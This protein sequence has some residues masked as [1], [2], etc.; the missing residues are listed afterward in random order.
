M[1]GYVINNS[2]NVGKSF[3]ARELGYSNFPKDEENAII[4][5]ETHNS[6]TH[7]FK[8]VNVIKFSGDQIKDI[9]FEILKYDNCI[10]D[11]GASNI[12]KF[13]A[14]LSRFKDLRD[15]VDHIIVPAFSGDKQSEDTAKTLNIL[16]TLGLD[17]KVKIVFNK[18]NDNVE[19]EFAYLFK[20]INK[21]GY[22]IDKRLCI[23]DYEV[24]QDLGRLK[25]LAIELLEDDTDYKS[26]SRQLHKEGKYK[27]AKDASDMRLAKS[28]SQA[29]VDECNK[30]YSLIVT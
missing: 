20:A 7:K 6:S 28:M 14:E 10:V 27:D 29:L 17:D 12:E 22:K 21:L 5:V 2:G 1:Q 3:L 30:V 9:A 15:D 16:K 24:V 23:S 4:E 18:V 26:L 11:V 19:E 25:K 13:L 8:A